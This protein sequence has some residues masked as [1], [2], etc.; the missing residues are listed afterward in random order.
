MTG[1]SMTAVA[2]A[3]AIAASTA[4]LFAADAFDGRWSVHAVTEAGECRQSLEVPVE[5]AGGEVRGA[6]AYA[7]AASG[8]IEASGELAFVIA[9]QGDEVSATGR[10]DLAEG[11]GEWAAEELGCAGRWVARRE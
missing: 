3:A 2:C 8:Q 1:R 7:I 10:L 4:P 5:I 11:E 6:G 9:H